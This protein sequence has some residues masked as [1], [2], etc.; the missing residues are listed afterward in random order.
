MFFFF[1]D[2]SFVELLFSK[3]LG[4]DQI[5]LIEFKLIRTPS[6][7]LLWLTAPATCC[8]VLHVF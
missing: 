7:I 2:K 1:F 5:K 3:V 8:K 6:L 4:N